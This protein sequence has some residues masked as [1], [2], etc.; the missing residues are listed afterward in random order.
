[1]NLIN[2][3]VVFIFILLTILSLNVSYKMA[4]QKDRIVLT[5]LL[6]FTVLQV[7]M[8]NI[9][10]LIIAIEVNKDFI[11]VGVVVLTLQLFFINLG[12][13][14]V[15]NKK[16]IFTAVRYKEHI[17]HKSIV[18]IAYALTF[19]LILILLKD[20]LTIFLDLI[21]NISK[22]MVVEAIGSMS[23]MRRELSFGGGSNA[24]IITQLKNT[25]L[26]FLSIYILS[27][28]FSK[29]IKIGILFTTLFVIL[30]SGQRWPLFEALMVYAIYYSI[31]HKVH[32]NWMKVIKISCIIF[33][34]MFILS[35]FQPR[36]LMTED[37]LTNL[38]LN[39][40]AIIYRLFVS[41]AMT[42]Y[43]IF[44]LIPE[45]LEFGMGTYL[46]QDLST[47]LPGYQEGFSTF[48][49]KLTHDGK[50]GSASFSTLSLFYADFGYFSIIVAFSFGILLQLYTNNIYRFSPSKIRLIFH[51][52][53]IM[54]LATTSLGSIS[55]VL[56][57]G[58][59]SGY[60][61]Y[62][63]LKI[64]FTLVSSKEKV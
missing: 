55:G 51:S 1:M 39:L 7:G 28:N 11:Y 41:Q 38:M 23:E 44:N 61:L 19:F 6:L 4:K 33:V 48:I 45:N 17:V 52:F 12:A 36:F 50:I 46:I 59:I 13:L 62:I 31:S 58:L 8:V 64:I 57:H 32:V 40:E 10:M 9:G 35:Y 22:G 2:F 3:M 49:Y 56:Y 29:F 18:L 43:Y 42:S 15:G 34:I 24:G 37:L 25:I 60:M 53:V 20:Y 21:I 16:Y 30:S 47:Y 27:S 54:A 26:V 14:I 5:P 63:L